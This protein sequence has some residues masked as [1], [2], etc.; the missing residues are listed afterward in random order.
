[1]SINAHDALAEQFL[2]G[3]MIDNETAIRTAFLAV[4]PDAYYSERHKMLADVI[5]DMVAKRIPV[6]LST[7][8]SAL[9]D[10]GLV[11]RIDPTY[12]AQLSHMAPVAA[13]AEH[14]ADRVCEL[15]GRRHLAERITRVLQRLDAAWDSGETEY[16]A[17]ASADLKGAVDEVSDMAGC[18]SSMKVTYLDEFLAQEFQYDWLVPGLLERGDRLLLTGDEGFGK[19]E[20]ISQLACAVAG[21]VHPFTGG[22]LDEDLRVAVVDCENSKMQSVRRYSRIKAGINNCRIMDGAEPLDWS[23]QLAIEFRPGGLNLMNP[24]DV[25]WLERYVSAA[26][27][28]MLVIGPLYKLH[29]EDENSSQALRAV[30]ATLDDI[31]DRHGCAIITEAHA[32]KAEADGA[33][34]M[35]PRGSSL[36]LGWPEFGLGLRRSK[37]DREDTADVVSW[38]GARDERMWP[39]RLSKATAGRLSWIPTDPDYYGMVADWANL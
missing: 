10:Q 3:S 38:R 31:R 32:G 39:T 16:L 30:T 35:A 23:K 26:T 27:P 22:V 28:D 36:L 14:Y 12:V 7:V 6:D 37:E 13:A 8:V 18:A 17:E 29:R 33:R 4:P 2:L 5:R 9:M 15:Y 19:S 1:M 11:S 20:L 21:A 34:K 25:S 24:Q